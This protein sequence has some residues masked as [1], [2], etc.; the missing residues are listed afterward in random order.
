MRSFCATVYNR[1][2]LIAKLVCGDLWDSLA[3]ESTDLQRNSR[4]PMTNG[5]M[6]REFEHM[7]EVFEWEGSV[8]VLYR[9]TIV[10]GNHICPVSN[11]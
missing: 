11:L 4:H 10:M 5:N 6:P 2:G 7:F 8:D 3:E 9:A 1:L